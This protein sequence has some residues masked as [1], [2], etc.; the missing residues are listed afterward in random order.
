[1]T[2]KLLHCGAAVFLFTVMPAFG[3]LRNAKKSPVNITG[4]REAPSRFE[5]EITELQSIA[6]PLGYSAEI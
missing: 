1:M 6:L 5:L 2:S 3:S 4:D